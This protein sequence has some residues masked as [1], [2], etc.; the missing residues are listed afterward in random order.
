MAAFTL[1]EYGMA[2]AIGMIALAA[3]CVLW[4]YASKTCAALLN[5]VEL[6]SASKNA[7]DRMSREIRN[8]TAVKSCSVNQLILLDPDGTNVTYAYHG[9]TKT[10][11]V[12]KYSQTTTL[13][14][15]CTAFEFKIYQRTPISGSYVLTETTD[16]NTAKVVSMRWTCARNLTGDRQ[17][18]E[19][20]VSSKVVIRSK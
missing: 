6:S 17:N 8:A 15:G 14:N 7:M 20:A 11:T 2:M 16:T 1:A 4:G 12:T 3:A 9:V 18:V 19:N 13:L 5:Y 10:L